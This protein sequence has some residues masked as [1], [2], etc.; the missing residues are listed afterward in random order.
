MTS[1][2]QNIDLDSIPSQFGLK[3][4]IIRLD[5]IPSYIGPKCAPPNR[6]N[7]SYQQLKKLLPTY[8]RLTQIKLSFPSKNILINDC[9]MLIDIE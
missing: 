9:A 5:P 7:I 2:L 8:F 4:V 6:Q 3:S 1:F